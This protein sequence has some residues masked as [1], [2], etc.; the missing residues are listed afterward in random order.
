MFQ[1]NPP[2][3]KL[4]CSKIYIFPQDT[5]EKAK[6]GGKRAVVEGKRDSYSST[7][8]NVCKGDL[9]RLK[10]GLEEASTCYLINWSTN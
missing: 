2:H 5:Y 10:A 9:E 7:C 6:K 3:K 1:K 8:E 4:Y